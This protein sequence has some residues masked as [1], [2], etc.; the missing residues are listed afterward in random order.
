MVGQRMASGR[1]RGGSGWA[2]DGQ[3]RVSGKGSGRAVEGQWMGSGWAVERAVARA[4]DGQWLVEEKGGGTPRQ[5]R[6]PQHRVR[7]AE[8]NGAAPIRMPAHRSSGRT[9]GRA[10]VTGARAL[11]G[12]G[13]SLAPSWLRHG[14]G[15]AGWL[16]WALGFGVGVRGLLR[17]G[18]CGLGWCGLGW[19]G[20]RACGRMV[21]LLPCGL[22]PAAGRSA[23]GR[24][25]AA[26]RPHRARPLRPGGPRGRRRA[27]KEMTQP[28][29]TAKLTLLSS[30]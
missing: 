8:H 1:S 16:V 21:G 30:L 7:A 15:S 22:S 29:S 18:W 25:A 20:V 24:A 12:N 17:A 23:C 14:S 26:R 3:W 5:G 2:V 9:I 6:P 13:C 19:C 11:E 4:V 27:I 10:A 28:L